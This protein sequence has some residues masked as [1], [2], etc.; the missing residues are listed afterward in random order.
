[1]KVLHINFSDLKGGASIACFRLNDCLIKNNYN[2]KLLV[3][4]K[5]SDNI[6]V[7][8]FNKIYSKFYY[9]LKKFLS[10]LLSK[11]YEK[12]KKKDI[13]LFIFES[14]LKNKIQKFNPDIINLHWICNET[15]SLKEINQ[16]NKPIIWTLCDMWPFL[17]LEHVD[18]NLNQKSYWN[19]EKILNSKKFDLNH[20]ALKRKISSLKSKI[21]IVAISSWLA[22]Q[23]KKSI[24]FGKLDIRV[25]PC[26]LDFDIWLPKKKLESRQNLNFNLDKK[27][28]LFVSSG[29]TNDKKKGFDFLLKALNKIDN[30]ENCH[31]VVLGKISTNHKRNLKIS[32]TEYN[33]FYNGD[34]KY[35]TEIYSASDL[36]VVPSLVEAFGQVALEAASCN[37]PTV[38]FGDTGLSE[39]ISHKKNGYLAHYKDVLDLK[40]GINWCF[41][42][43]NYNLISNQARSLA[44]SKF[45]YDCV[46]EQY[47]NLYD[48]I[49]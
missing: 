2:S 31:L 47:L 4:E 20:Y 3:A 16:I 42:H 27:I 32:F 24:L 23:A 25:I 11:V 18:F 22:K 34:P 49:K 46:Y 8:T 15:L 19:D 29:N 40:K 5:F 12:I 13:S 9:K 36:L 26:C 21:K 33:K 7:I 44:K 10:R 39:I 14:N 43:K 17:G 37:L 48:E 38:A 45:S 1:M 30:I 35:L 41:N 28:I 6:N